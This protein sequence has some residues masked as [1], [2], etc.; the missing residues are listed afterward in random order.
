MRI[1]DNGIHIIRGLPAA[2]CFRQAYQIT[3]RLLVHEDVLSCGPLL[4]CSDLQEWT[5]I[6]TKF[7]RNLFKDWPD[8][9]LTGSEIA[10]LNNVN[11][12]N[13]FEHIYV[14]VSTGLEDQLLILFVIYLIEL[15]GS[16][17]EKI[18]VVQYESHPSGNFLI[19]SMGQ[20]S[21]E[22]MSVHPAP[23]L[24]TQTHI[25]AYQK[26][27]AALT[28]DSPSQL[29]QLV[30]SSRQPNKHTIKALQYMLR[31]YPYSDTGLNFWDYQLL[32]NVQKHGPSVSR[33]IG[34]TLA[35]DLIEEDSVGDLYLF[36]RLN[37]L[38]SNEIAE[39]LFTLS[40]TQTSSFSSSEVTLT[41][42]G[43]AVLS[44]EVSSYPTNTIDYWVGGVHLSS[45]N[46]NLWFIKNNQLIEENEI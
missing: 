44:G 28:S 41:N 38:S 1:T 12:L 36:S 14:W 13:D 10:L 11:L 39:P 29:A 40:G 24:L 25:K 6:R 5:N 37:K 43:K 2:G 23:T 35:S 42:F 7:L 32:A 34:Y 27:W 17:P 9:I 20:L 3:D 22:Q 15:I 19:S 33:V 18:R 16:N 30:T 45:S 4:Q 26:A 21:P 46:N 8:M 31:R